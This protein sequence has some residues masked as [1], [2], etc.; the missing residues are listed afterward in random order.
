MM[1][2][3]FFVTLSAVTVGVVMMLARPPA[4]KKAVKARLAAIGQPMQQDPGGISLTERQGATWSDRVTD[5]LRQHS[6]GVTL[7]R[8]ITHAGSE[9]TSGQ[10][11]LVGLAIAAPFG[12]IAQELRGFLPLSLLAGAVGLLAPI[13]YLMW[14]KSSRIKKFNDALPDAIE[15]M[16]RALRAGHSV[17]SSVEMIAQQSKEPLSSEF[18]SCFQQQKFGI[19]FRDAMLT[20]GERV[21]DPDLQFFITAV[22]VQKETGGDLTEILDRTTRLIRDRVRIKGEIQSYTAQGRLTGWILSALPVILLVVMNL[23]SPGYSDV[24]FTDPLGKLLLTAGA[25]AIAI[26]GF[27]ISKIVDIKV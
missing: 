14:K 17:S 3:L 8:L 16:A 25:V 27:I 6:L 18:A 2:L 4:T 1:L 26:G 21:P 20:M 13:G 11:V 10:V 7:D 22:L 23:L 24:L 12:F 9:A 5:L 19:P 15:L